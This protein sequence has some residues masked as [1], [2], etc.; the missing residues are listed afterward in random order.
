MMGVARNEG[1]LSLIALV[2][3]LVLL[4]SITPAQEQPTFRTQS[5]VVLVPALVRDKSGNVVYGV[6]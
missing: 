4:C 5:N 2:L 6:K 1:L 3:Q